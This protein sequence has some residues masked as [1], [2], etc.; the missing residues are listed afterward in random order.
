MKILTADEMGKADRV[1]TDRFGIPSLELM[2]HAGR[3]VARFVLRELPQCRHIV[4][5]C[6]KGNNGGDGLVAA[7]HLIEAGCTVSVVILGRSGGDAR[8]TPKTMLERLPVAPIGIK[9][10][11]DLYGERLQSPVRG[12]AALCRCGSGHR[13]SSPDARPGNRRPQAAGALSPNPGGSGGSAV[14]LGR[15]LAK[16]LLARSLSRR[17]RG[18]VY[19]AQAGP[20]FGNAH[21]GTDRGGA[22]RF[23]GRGGRVRPLAS[24]GRE[25]PK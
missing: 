18:H 5:L 6:G 14:G 7:R 1:T 8:A 25:A 15:G 2:E 22:H 3:A 10:E 23:T 12:R 13:F 19:R 4:V 11:A 20:R 21:P 16:F 9:E 24:P 17:C